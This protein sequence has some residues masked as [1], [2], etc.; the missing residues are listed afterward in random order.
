[1][2]T[3]TVSGAPFAYCLEGPA[4]APVVMFANSL[5]TTMALWGQ[6]AE[7]LRAHYRVLRYDARGH[8][9]SVVSP[10][11]YTLAQ[12]GNDAVALLDALEIEQV[13][14]CGISMGGLIGLWL[15]VHA[16]PRLRHLI[17]ANSAAKIGEE[18]G[19]RTR[20]NDV[21][22]N[23]MNAVADGAAARWFTPAF[24]ARAPALVQAQVAQLRAGSPAGYAACCLALATA[25]LREDIARIQTPTLLLA[26]IDDPVTTL[27]HMHALRAGIPGAELMALDASHLS[28]L[29]AAEAFT[30]AVRQFID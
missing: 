2:S 22:A 4:G 21:L 28:N 10:T 17:V 1:M 15:G 11:P 9:G 3:I 14:F 26:G 30:Q 6:Q 16:G 19:W 13:S 8:G 23:G 27:N 24:I 7:A 20:A 12:M 18:S 25:D 5:G 29:E